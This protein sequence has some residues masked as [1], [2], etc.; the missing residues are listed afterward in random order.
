MKLAIELRSRLENPALDPNERARLSC[1]LAREFEE[2]GDYQ[3]ARDALGELWSGVGARPAVEGLDARMRAEVLLRA[4]VLTGW[5]GSANQ[6]EGAQESAKD[7][8]SES[9]T[10][11]QTLEDAAKVA[12]AQN[13]LAFCYWREGAFDEARVV[14]REVLDNLPD[15][16][17][18]LADRGGEQRAV[19]L[20]RLAG[21]ENSA[22]RFNDSLNLLNEAAPLFAASANHA[23]KGKFHN[24]LATNLRDLAAAENREEYLDRA[25]VEYAAASFHFEEAGHARYCAAVE[26]NLGG[27]FLNNGRYAEAHQHLDRAR[28]LFVALKDH[29]RTAQ[30]DETRARAL[31]AEGRAREAERA[32][33][34]AL[35]TLE[36]G[37]EDALLA[38]ALTTRATVLARM[39]KAAEAR[40]TFARAV[41]VAEQAGD[42]EGAGLASLAQLEE[43]GGQLDADELCEIYERADRWLARSQH[44]RILA[45]LRECARRVVAARRT[46]LPQSNVSDIA[47]TAA[48][49][50]EDA[51]ARKGKNLSFTPEAFE[52]LRE[53]FLRDRTDEL[54]ALVERTIEAASEGAQIT[55]D[56]VETVALRL[57]PD[58]GLANPWA[59]FSLKEDVR[60]FEERFICLA[61]REAQGKVTH[62]ATLLGFNHPASLK[63]LLETK[64]PGLLSERTPA[65]PRKRSIIR[66]R[67]RRQN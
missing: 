48:R 2:A 61:L 1:D 55:A 12:E 9:Q 53:H 58:A 27:L 49:I 66:D 20:L 17:G 25:L 22:T 43:S 37:D 10:I 18:N 14:L 4:G 44:P 50:V 16:G 41:G 67:R 33:A 45:R 8:I 35:D 19:A 36:R 32:I 26:N 29:V 51:L 7:L 30:V 15:D 59:G 24:E 39:G 65:T 6:L 34:S 13:E 52:A 28:K 42:I 47:D 31:L 21:V 56:A 57:T 5:I 40:A 60:R 3:S 62:A 23:L 64:H 63:S 38:E 54:R 11:F 46:R